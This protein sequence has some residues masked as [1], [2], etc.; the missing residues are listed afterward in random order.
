MKAVAVKELKNR[1]S[2]SLREGKH[3]E[4]AL[5][6]DRGV[7]VAELRQPSAVLRSSFGS[8][9]GEAIGAARRAPRIP[10]G[11]FSQLESL[12]ASAF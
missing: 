2:P 5:V 4:V 12:R 9:V 8:E 7:V 1:L 6:T 11:G 10:S 3:E